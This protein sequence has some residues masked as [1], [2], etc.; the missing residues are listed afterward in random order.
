MRKVVN[1]KPVET[2][3]LVANDDAISV[4]EAAL[5]L[6]LKY[7]AARNTILGKNEKGQPN[8]TIYDYGSR[9]WKVSK[10]SILAYKKAHQVKGQY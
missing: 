2:E 8:I 7:G 3:N 10:S 6:G 5:I 9:N 4:K 1:I